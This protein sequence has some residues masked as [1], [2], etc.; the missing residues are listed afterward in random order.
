[1]TERATSDLSGYSRGIY[2][3]PGFTKRFIASVAMIPIA[4][5]L[6]VQALVVA[7]DLISGLKFGQTR[8]FHMSLTAILVCSLGWIWRRVLLSHGTRVWWA[9]AVGVL[10]FLQSA[11]GSL[12]FPYSGRRPEDFLQFGQFHLEMGL[13]TWAALWIWSRSEKPL[14]ADDIGQ[15][16]S[17][18]PSFSPTAK[19]LIASVS[20]WFILFGVFMISHE[21]FR[22]LPV[23]KDRVPVSLLITAVIGVAIWYIIWCRAFN[24]REGALLQTTIATIICLVLPLFGCFA[25]YRQIGRFFDPVLACLPVIGWGVWMIWTSRIW[26][27]RGSDALPIDAPRCIK[28]GYLLIGLR[29]TRCPECGSEPTLDELWRANSCD[30]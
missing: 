9:L 11:Y 15:R 12:P 24:W 19:R 25:F 2:S 8:F 17:T 5:G 4:Y 29:S 27:A 6:S 7:L 22:S 28:C 23:P 13:C 3:A 26:L 30:I 20:L 18:V 14:M 21:V 16:A 10:P 1:M